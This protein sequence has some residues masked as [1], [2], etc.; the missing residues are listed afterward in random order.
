MENIRAVF[1]DLDDTLL[2][3]KGTFLLYCDHMIRTFFPNSISQ[4]ESE[5]IKHF[6]VEADKDGYELRSVFYQ[7]I[8]EKYSLPFSAAEL[9]QEWFC[10][11]HRFCV[12]M[13]GLMETLKYLGAK[14]KLG[15]ITNGASLMQ[16]KKID[17]LGIRPFFDAIIISSEAGIKKPDEKIF[18]MACEALNA[19][20]KSAVFVGDNY[21]KDVMG[22]KNAGMHPVWMKRHSSAYEEAFPLTIRALK[23]LTEFL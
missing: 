23:D 16:N 6:I 14:Y 1:F 8:V 4:T 9:E 15:I 13:D 19:D 11:F 3:R 22:A 12:P 18:R 17:S 20:N 7:T 21:E 2:D 5:I 10:S